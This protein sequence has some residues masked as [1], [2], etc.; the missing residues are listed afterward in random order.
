MT[1]GQPIDG[2]LS[3]ED[4]ANQLYWEGVRPI[5]VVTDEPEKYPATTRWP[6]GTT[7]RH[8]KDL[9]LV[10]K[11]LQQVK[12]VSAL[13]YDQTCA[14]EKRRRRKRG[15]FP[16]PQ[17]RVFINQEV[18]EGCGDCNKK[19]NCVSVVP[20]DTEFGRKR[21]IDQSSCNK[22]YSC[23]EGFCPSFVSVLGGGPRKGEAAK[24][25]DELASILL[26]PAGAEDPSAR[27]GLQRPDHRYRR[28]RGPHCRGD[29]RH[30]GT[31]GRQILQRHG[32]HGHGAEGRRGHHPSALR[33]IQGQAIRD[34]AVAAVGRPRHRLRPRRYHRPGDARPGA[35][36]QRPD[37]GQQR[38][39]SDRSVSGQ[40]GTGPEPGEAADRSSESCDRR[41]PV[42]DCGRRR[43]RCA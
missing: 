43:Q 30:G 2:K 38:R 19:S 11:D 26:R 16:N 5:V 33:C 35:F 41:A 14:A 15:T 28:H 10:Q 34:A 12:G 39:G 29:P 24:A 6:E 36:R 31:P 9:E 40:P 37:P 20:L 23:L 27:R 1:G 7:V 32:H 13:I 3:V 25:P 21:K 42:S 8:R 18:C 4:V 22:D 17:K